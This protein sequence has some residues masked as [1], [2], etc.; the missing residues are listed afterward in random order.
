MKRRVQI[1]EAWSVAMKFD[2]ILHW[3]WKSGLRR[4]HRVQAHRW[5]IIEVIVLRFKMRSNFMDYLVWPWKVC[6]AD[7]RYDMYVINNFFAY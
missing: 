4:W 5:W 6:Q 2:G 3:S 1:F 7:W